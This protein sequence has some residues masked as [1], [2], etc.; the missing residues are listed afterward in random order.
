MISLI[1]LTIYCSHN[2]HINIKNKY[3]T[4][5][6]AI[7]R[8]FILITSL[9]SQQTLLSMPNCLNGLDV[10]SIRSNGF[11]GSHLNIPQIYTPASQSSVSLP[12]HPVISEQQVCGQF[13]H[14][15]LL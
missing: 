11:N 15:M 13:R 10:S 5:H 3:D 4:N 6:N 2:K 1:V 9:N 8:E 7:I 12:A 14:Y